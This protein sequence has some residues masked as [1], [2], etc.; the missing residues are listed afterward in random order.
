M[1]KSSSGELACDAYCSPRGAVQLLGIGTGGSITGKHADLIVTDDIINVKD[2]VSHSER[3]R[4]KVIYQELQNIR[5]R[6]GRIINTGTP[7]HKEDAF[8]LMPNIHRFDC[9]Q[10]GLITHDKL[11]ELRR[12]MSPAL[13]AANY[14]L[15]HIAAENALFPD[16][17]VFT[18]ETALIRDGIA[19]IDAAYGGE[20]YTALTIGKRVEGKLVLY[21]RMW[22][23]H[24]DTSLDAAL[25]ECER[26][27]AA[28]VYCENNGDKGYLGKEIRRRGVPVRIY[29]ESQNKYSKIATYLRKWWT[30]I[31]W[32]EGTDPEYLSMIMDYTEDA[33]H[34]DAPDSA[35]CVCRLL[36]KRYEG[37]ILDG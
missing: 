5:N 13:F 34:D 35:A 3:E 1:T 23:S 20:D 24:V 17:P 28:P 31:L 32:L 10:T 22:H 8:S 36:D 4:T 30:N 15:R 7:W 33:E 27:M 19:H 14:E 2:R 9:Y 37:L 26:L 21:G 18:Q 16:A 25:A 11:E 29:H 6:G 12:S